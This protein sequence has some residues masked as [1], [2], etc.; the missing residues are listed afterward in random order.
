MATDYGDKERAFIDGLKEA[1]GRDLAEWM[2]AISAAGLPHRNDIIDWLRQQ[3]FL[4]S[5]AS[6]LERIH[7]NG[8]K[9]IYADAAAAKRRVLREPRVLA[10]PAAAPTPQA[11]TPQPA[12][13]PPAPPEPALPPKVAEPPQQVAEPPPMPAAAPL[14]APASA[15]TPPPAAASEEDLAPLLA[16]AKAYRPLAQAVIA[17][18]KGVR[19]SARFLARETFIAIADP[20]PFA[21]L[22]ISAKELRLHLALGTHAPDDLVKKGAPGAG[23]GKEDTLSHMVVLTDARQ[24]DRRLADLVARAAR[25]V[26]G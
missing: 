9:P 2:T 8:G 21:H 25:N 17:H 1:T 20:E 15:A 26:N 18:I 3:G 22:G 24:I 14:Q 13:S 11:A 23:L 5:K 10:A 19:P 4:F 7:H 12:P 6:W 16:K